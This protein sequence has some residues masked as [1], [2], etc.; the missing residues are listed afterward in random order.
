MSWWQKKENRPVVAAAVIAGIL[1]IL[2]SLLGKAYFQQRT[3]KQHATEAASQA[4]AS[5]KIARQEANKGERA[6]EQAGELVSYIMKDLNDA[7]IPIGQAK[8]LQ[9]LS[10]QAL[11]YFENLP[12]DLIT[13]DTEIQQASVYQSLAS[14]RYSLGDLENSIKAHHQAISIYRKL[15]KIDPAAPKLQDA[16]RHALCELGIV[17]NESEQTDLARGVYLDAIEIPAAG[18][19]AAHAAAQ[20]GLGE[21]ERLEG[22][23]EL[24]LTRY[25]KTATLL[26]KAL[27]ED[28]EN[29]FWRQTLMTC[30]NNAGLLS[31]NLGNDADAQNHFQTSLDAARH[32]VKLD[33]E[34]R[35]WQK[36]LAT[37]LN[38][39]GGLLEEQHQIDQAEPFFQEAL[40]LR[41]GLVLW[42]P[43]NT[44]W[45]L[46]LA[47]S[48]H[49]DASLHHHRKNGP[50]TLNSARKS[51]QVFQKLLTLEPQN[52]VWLKDMMYTLEVNRNRL[53]ELNQSEAALILT[54]E[55]QQFVDRLKSDSSDTLAWNQALAGLHKELGNM[56]QDRGDKEDLVTHYR[57]AAETYAQEIGDDLE[58]KEALLLL[59][60]SYLDL[61]EAF[62]EKQDAEIAFVLAEFILT[63]ILTEETS[64]LKR[65]RDFSSRQRILASEKPPVTLVHSG[66]TWKYW[67]KRESPGQSW[68]E[69]SFDDSSWKE[70]AAPLGYGDGDEATEIRFGSRSNNKRI[71][72][73]FRHHFSVENPEAIKSLQI[74]LRRDDGAVVYLNGKEII[75]DG[76]PKR[77][78]NPTTLADM[79]K[80]FDERVFHRFQI[81]ATNLRTENVISVE[82]HQ[83]EAQSSDLTL[84]LELWNTQ[85]IP[86]PPNLSD[87]SDLSAAE[88]VLGPKTIPNALRNSVKR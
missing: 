45:L 61:G 67:D 38:N 5:A 31:Q 12:P 17:Y 66:S 86:P 87:L 16:L 65:L 29:I 44:R 39:F 64:S 68:T 57:K 19:P 25:R 10:L 2:A 46:N 7:L 43:K 33:P 22:L 21:V 70:G 54:T 55:T 34:N 88:K 11:N 78:I 69:L 27:E 80:G 42:D 52:T 30:H 82:V 63:K 74:N 71:T 24:A 3:L 23:P 48:W 18:Q 73:W 1:S 4:K 9:Q 49:N 26:N 28:P 75:R 79:S 6:R 77:K 62:N 58:K 83:N 81:P 50:Q 60:E 41:Q 53:Q 8:V 32:L 51:L 15:L 85:T 14:A 20:F 13:P 76:L 35:H 56:R 84:D 36:E 59:A 40:K 47:N 37:L 72:A